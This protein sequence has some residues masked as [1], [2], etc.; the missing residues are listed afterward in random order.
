M[1]LC[2]VVSRVQSSG[3]RAAA[4]DIESLKVG[5]SLAT[6]MVKATF[7][8]EQLAFATLKKC[9]AIHAVMPV[10]MQGS[11]ATRILNHFA[12]ESIF[13]S[14]FHS[15]VSSCRF[16]LRSII[17]HARRSNAIPTALAATTMLNGSFSVVR[18]GTSSDE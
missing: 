7:G 14:L 10:V 4:L 6:G 5:S 15:P 13:L 12:L 8:T 1:E 2:E 18:S 11:I 9:T 3:I 17:Y 16:K